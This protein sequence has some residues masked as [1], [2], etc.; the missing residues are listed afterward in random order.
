MVLALSRPVA[1]EVLM[2]FSPDPQVP[3]SRAHPF[4]AACFTNTTGGTVERG[5]IAMFDQGTF[6]GQGLLDPL[7]AGATATLPFALERSVEV[8]RAS[9]RDDGAARVASIEHGQL[10]VVQDR[11]TTYRA[12]NGG[13][14]PARLL[15]RHPRLAD[16]LLVSAPDGTKEELARDS[17][18]VPMT[19]AAHATEE[20]DVDETGTARRT[21]DWLTDAADQAVRR[22]LADPK[23]SPEAVQKLSAAWAIRKELV[24]KNAERTSLQQESYTLGQEGPRAAAANAKIAANTRRIAELD[25]KIAELTA[26]LH[27]ALLGIRVTAP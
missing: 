23:A 15:L 12:H 8:W 24:K 21:A 18:L 22:Y 2:L 11:V 3:D 1:G 5:P 16:S 13:D 14:E 6:L 25:A 20:T 19:V 26:Q 9:N 7:P 27:D 17:A 10:M 4:R